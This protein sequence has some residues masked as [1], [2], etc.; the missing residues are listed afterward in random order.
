MPKL[1]KFTI[2]IG[3]YSFIFKICVKKV[4]FSCKKVLF[5][6]WFYAFFLAFFSR[7]MAVRPLVLIL[8]ALRWIGLKA[9]VH[10]CFFFVSQLWKVHFWNIWESKCGLRMVKSSNTVNVTF[11]ANGLCKESRIGFWNGRR[12]LLSA[13]KNIYWFL[14]STKVVFF[15]SW[16]IID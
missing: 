1:R 6:W 11:F 14:D 3:K 13:D 15:W 4:L 7:K 2:I 8:T 16:R 10:L 12:S 5:F 9:N